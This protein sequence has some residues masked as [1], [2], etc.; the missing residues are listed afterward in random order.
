MAPLSL[1]LLA[2]L[3]STAT[4]AAETRNSTKPNIIFVLADD[5][6]WMDVGYNGARFY[7]TPHIDRLAKDGLVFDRAYASGPNCSPSRA[8][9]LSGMY[10]PRHR[11]YTPGNRSKGPTKF[12]RLRV[13]AWR[14]KQ[15]VG[16]PASKLALEPGVVS[17]AEVL[18]QVGYATARFGKWHVGPDTQGFDV[19]SSDG[20]PRR[21]AKHYGDVDVAEALTDASIEFI[22]AHQGEPFFILLSHWDVH[23]PIQARQNVVARFEKKRALFPESWLNAEYAGMIEAVD[24]SVGRLRE[25]LDELHLAEKTLFLFSSDNGGNSSVTRNLP[26]RGGKGALTEGGIRVPTLAAWPGVVTSGT[27]SVVPIT[28]VDFLPT[29]AELAGAV[30][31]D[32]QP[33][34]G[35]SIVPLLEGRAA[36]HLRDRPVFWFFPLYLQGGPGDAVAPIFGSSSMFWRGVPS[37][38]VIRGDAKL[39]HFFEDGSV[40][41]YDLADDPGELNNLAPTRI[42]EA[43]ELD[44]VLANWL[45]QT[46]A[47]IPMEL[48]NGFGKEGIRD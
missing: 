13:P 23:V 7:E 1:A 47:K 18:E 14:G 22:E 5:L 8:S 20:T 3:V 24:R 44:Q 35:I 48:N 41:L 12:M 43:R 9:L 29:F 28:S 46:G 37:A 36:L 11:I 39:T 27:R 40:A 16:P 34:D 33:V 38:T 17:L 15:A 19:S 30:L 10:T 2:L 4:F 21:E 31:P 26:L 32:S 42:E 45:A 6:G 25:K